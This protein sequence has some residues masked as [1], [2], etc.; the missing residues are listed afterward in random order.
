MHNKCSDNDMCKEN[1]IS[2]KTFSYS[3][4]KIK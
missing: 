4:F 2:S 3:D 1:S